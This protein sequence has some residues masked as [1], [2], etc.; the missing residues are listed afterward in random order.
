MR[1]PGSAEERMK[2]ALACDADLCNIDTFARH[3]RNTMKI[4][5]LGQETSGPSKREAAF[6]TEENSK[7]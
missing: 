4:S 5:S 6:F 2:I 7:N 1:F 3:I